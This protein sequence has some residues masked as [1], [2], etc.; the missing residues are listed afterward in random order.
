MQYGNIPQNRERIYIIGFRTKKDFDKFVLPSPI[1]LRCNVGDIININDR[2]DDKYYYT[3]SSKFYE[4]L[5]ESVAKEYVIYQ[6]RRTYVRENK[7]GVCPTLTAN[8]GTGGNNV[9]IIKDNF[10]IRKLTPEECFKFQGFSGIDIPKGVSNSQLYKQA[11]NSITVPVVERIAMNIVDALDGKNLNNYIHDL[12]PAQK[13]GTQLSF[14][15]IMETV[16]EKN[17]YTC[18]A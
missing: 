4:L 11:G 7:S 18:S 16:L 10:G 9:P 1:P 13:D 3:Q 2:K 5:T 8:M 15:C 6:L 12:Y 17:Q 14:D